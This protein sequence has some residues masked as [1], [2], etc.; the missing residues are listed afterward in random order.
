MKSIDPQRFEEV[1]AED[2]D[3]L[4]NLRNNGDI[5][6]IPRAIDVSFRGSVASLR[7]LASACGNFGFEVQRRI[8]ADEN[9]EPWLFIVRTQAADEESIRELTVTYLQIEDAFKVRCDGWG[10][11]GQTEQS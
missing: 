4:R 9:G 10:C 6:S 1:W 5:P 2:R 3:V 11:I 7:A 8:E